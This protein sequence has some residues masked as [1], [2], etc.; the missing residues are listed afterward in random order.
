M[1]VNISTVGAT[2]RDYATI[3]IWEAATDND[4]VAAGDIEVGECYADANFN[5]K[6]IIAGATT[7]VSNHRILR[8]ATGE[9]H[10]GTVS[11]AGAIVQSTSNGTLF[12]VFESFLQLGSGMVLNLT[13]ASTSDECIRVGDGSNTAEGLLVENCVIQNTDG[14]SSIDCVYAGAYSVGSA[15]NPI[16]L[17]NCSITGAVRAGIHAQSHSNTTQT[18]Q[19]WD[20]I[21]CTLTDSASNIGVQ[22]RKSDS[23]LTIRIINT[24][25]GDAGTR[26]YGTTGTSAGTTTTTGSTNNWDE[27]TE[28]PG[29]FSESP[30]TLV[31]SS[32]GGTECIIVAK[33]DDHKLVD[34]G[35]NDVLLDGV[36][37]GSNSL[38]PTDDFIGN[39]RGTGSTCDPGCSQ[40][41]SAASDDITS[42]LVGTATLVGVL[43]GIGTLTTA[44]AGDAV[45]PDGITGVGTITTAV[46]GDAVLP[47]GITGVGTLATAV[48]GDAVLPDGVTGV[49]TLTT[50]MVGDAALPDTLGAGA[51]PDIA[52][53][54]VGDAALA[55]DL[56]GVGTIA[57][58]MVGDAV[59]PD[60]VTGVGTLTTAMVGDAVLPDGLTAS[61]DP[62]IVTALVGD[63]VLAGD[64]TG[65]GTLATAMVGDASLP[66]GITGTGLLSTAMVG[67]ASVTT[68]LLGIGVLS[69]ALVGDAVLA[70][71]FDSIGTL[72][73]A[74]VG[75]AS[76][77]SN[78]VDPSSVAYLTGRGQ[79]VGGGVTA[80]R[81]RFGGATQG[82]VTGGGATA[83]KVK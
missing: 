41:S 83:G 11:G 67:D 7:D 38:V 64:L 81:V 13:T 26:D 39:D 5:E 46:V 29:K 18:D 73:S 53:A 79:V 68:N 12:K 28:V 31:T 19:Y 20:V 43:T 3:T 76:V 37:N 51:D 24:I 33:Y 65:V 49:G 66:D 56:T 72:T 6:I 1:T 40:V 9:K 25:L 45:L 70:S 17:R 23:T 52:T 22:A 32:A 2:A 27:L 55:G 60:G 59:L 15:S 57:T 14:S 54:M 36:G 47:D 30:M 61:D 71:A 21:N 77:I 44:L 4:L 35:D 48:V 69:S 34:S 74:M 58:A 62:D 80:G 82:Q 75:D 50:A 8:A 63:A 16:T 78:L 42:A 10:D